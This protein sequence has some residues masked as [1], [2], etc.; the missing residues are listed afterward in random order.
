MNVREKNEQLLTAKPGQLDFWPKI[1]EYQESRNL[2]FFEFPLGRELPTEPGLITIRGPRQYGKSTWLELS[3]RDTLEEYKPGSVFYLNGD[4]LNSHEQLAD[5]LVLLESLFAKKAKIKRI[6]IDEITSVD[7]WERAFK[8]LYDAGHLRDVL[9]VTTGSNARDLRRGAERLP[10][11]KG[12]LDRTEYI[13]LPVSYQQFYKTCFSELQHYSDVP[14]WVIYLLS[15]G[16]PLAINEILFDGILP[17]FLVN[18]TKD[19][20]L[21]DILTQG[22]DRIFLKNILDVIYR[23]GAS[24]VGFAK[25]A[26]EA[27]LANNTVA[28]GYIE[29]LSDL[30]VLKPI[31]QKDVEKNIFLQRKPCKFLFTNT[32]AATAFHP[33]AIRYISDFEKLSPLERG[34]M[35]EFLVSQELLR[36]A[37]WSGEDLDSSLGFWRSEN[38]EIDFVYKNDFFEVKSGEASLTDFKWFH[39]VFPAKNLNALSQSSFESQ[40]ISGKKIHDFLMSGNTFDFIEGW[41]NPDHSKLGQ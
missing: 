6:F 18:L 24:P 30:L 27:G 8:R 22:R 10:G 37:A 35:V 40:K 2:F 19:W 15:G 26:R 3:I 21:G 1:K 11:R 38:H 4:E 28:A 32:L 17:E 9:V 14:A 36:R 25:L 41:H 5:E 7:N 39:K 13:F 12:R 29:Q 23:L 34:A 33:R 20:V 31:M 16:S